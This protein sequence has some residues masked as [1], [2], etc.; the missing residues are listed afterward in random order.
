MRSVKPIAIGLMLIVA[1]AGCG[2]KDSVSSTKKGGK[3]KPATVKLS[4]EDEMALANAESVVG[5]MASRAEECL[6]KQATCDADTIGKLNAA[7]IL[8]EAATAI[9]NGG[10]PGGVTVITTGKNQ[11]VIT[12][13][14][15]DIKGIGS[16]TYS[17][18][19]NNN[20]FT[21]SCKPDVPK[22][23][24]NGVWGSAVQD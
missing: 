16:V 11:Y 14:T 6:G 21:N 5:Y 23:C 24:E 10:G 20:E 2:S 19:R 4:A 18:T 13:S 8:P 15:A 1:A 3:A 22:H 12:G 7:T 9:A 17:Y